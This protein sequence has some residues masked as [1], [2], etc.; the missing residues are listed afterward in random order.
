[1]GL[2]DQM[3]DRICEILGP[4]QRGLTPGFPCL[5]NHQGC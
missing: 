2:A 1:M 4:P 3:E 5:K